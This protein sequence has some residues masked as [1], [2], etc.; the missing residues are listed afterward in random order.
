MKFRKSF[1]TVLLSL[2]TVFAGLVVAQPAQ[3]IDVSVCKIKSNYP[4]PSTHVTGTINAVSTISCDRKMGSIFLRNTLVKGNGAQWPGSVLSNVNIKSGQSVS[5][6][7]CSQG[8]G[9][10]FRTSTYYSIVFPAPLQPQNASGWN[11]SPWVPAI[12]GGQIASMPTGTIEKTITIDWSTGT[13][14]ESPARYSTS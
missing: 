4:H 9:A 6:T 1:S 7:S 11:Y 2:M 12:C 3:A 10:N 13:V 14:D 8:P 5:N